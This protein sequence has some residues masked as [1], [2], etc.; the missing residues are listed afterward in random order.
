MLFASFC[1]GTDV[2]RLG[3]RPPTPVA[4]SGAGSCPLETRD[5]FAV[6]GAAHRN[7][8]FWDKAAVNESASL[9]GAL[10]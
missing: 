8:R 1:D 3:Q 6:C 2:M 5:R 7:V 4:V 10:R 9:R